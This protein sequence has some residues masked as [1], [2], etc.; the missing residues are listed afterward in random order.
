MITKAQN[1]LYWREWSRAK[2][3]AQLTDADRHRLHVEALGY[4]KSHTSFENAE[5]DKVLG[6][7][8]AHSQPAN[9]KAQLAQLAQPDTRLIAKI[10]AQVK[11]LALFVDQPDAYLRRLLRDRFRTTYLED[12]HSGRS[13]PALGSE[14]FCQGQENG[15]PSAA[16]TE[17]IPANDLTHVR[18]TIAARLSFHRRKHVPAL[19]EHGMWF[20]AGLTPEYCRCVVCE[21]LKKRVAPNFNFQPIETIPGEELVD[22][23]F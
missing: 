11:C 3:A 14:P 15:S 22:Q 13:V 20:K 9:L 21:R 2:K 17:E 23:P 8:R 5:L 6:V 4:D 18:N 7:F 1:S 10:R 12:L 19:T 16:S